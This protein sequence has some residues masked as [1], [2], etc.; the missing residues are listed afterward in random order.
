MAVGSKFCES[1]W[2]RESNDTPEES[3]NNENANVE[4]WKINGTEKI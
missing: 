4:P 2:E 3:K 1:E